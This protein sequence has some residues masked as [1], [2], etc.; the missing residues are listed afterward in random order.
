MSE[1]NDDDAIDIN[2]LYSKMK[3]F[4]DKELSER[5]QIV[6][7]QNKHDIKNIINHKIFKLQS[8]SDTSG[9]YAII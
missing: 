4:R 6:S 9:M 3:L 1:E 7:N 8:I 5:Q 2:Y